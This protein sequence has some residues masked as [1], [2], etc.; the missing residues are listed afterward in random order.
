MRAA[1]GAKVADLQTQIDGVAFTNTDLVTLTIGVH[2]VVAQFQ[3]LSEAAPPALDDLKA[4]LQSAGESAA[5]QLCPVLATG[6]K[7]VL[8][9]APDLG[10]SPYGLAQGPAGASQL[11]QLTDAF[12][13]ALRLSVGDCRVDGNPADGWDWGLI[14]GQEKIVQAV[15]SPLIYG[16]LR[17][18][19]NVVGAACRGA[20]LDLSDQPGT[21][22][23]TSTLEVGASAESWLWSQ[24]LLP[25]YAWHRLVANG[26]IGLRFYPR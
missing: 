21:A 23:D 18:P 22:C 11:T 13:G 19:A 3:R 17:N 5:A 9:T 14:D 26:L 6:A 12:T 2:D 24:A 15:K 16:G 1:A 10:L 25:S 7:V 4:A 20:Q 8:V